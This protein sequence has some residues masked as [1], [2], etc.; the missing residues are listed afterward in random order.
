MFGGFQ[1]TRVGSDLLSKALSAALRNLLSN[2]SKGFELTG[3]EK[4]LQI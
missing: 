1:N 4:L 3:I 2:R